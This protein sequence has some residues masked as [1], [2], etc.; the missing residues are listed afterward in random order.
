[1]MDLEGA[2]KWELYNTGSRKGTKR[3]SRFIAS[4]S[5][6]EASSFI[7]DFRNYVLRGQNLDG[8][9]T[10]LEP[11]CY[12]CEVLHMRI[13]MINNTLDHD[14]ELYMQVRMPSPYFLDFGRACAQ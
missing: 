1:M 7:T 3:G 10:S 11:S 6:W 13:N 2:K 9:I 12:V 8:P 5:S 14:N 4:S